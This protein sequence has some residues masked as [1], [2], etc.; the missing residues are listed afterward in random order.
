M[1]AE[2][3]PVNTMALGCRMA[4]IAAMKNVLSPSSLTMIID[5]EAMKAW[6]NPAL[7]SFSIFYKK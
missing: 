4:M 5:R 7:V 1:R 3:A 6:V 2:M